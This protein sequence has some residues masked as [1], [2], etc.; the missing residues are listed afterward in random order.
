MKFL[1]LAVK[2]FQLS[3]IRVGIGWM[4]GLL[5]FN[6][7]RVTITDLGAIGLVVLTLIGLH[8]FLSPLQVFW[9]RL[10]DR[11]PLFGYRRSPSILLG[12]LVTSLVFLALPGLAVGLGQQALWATL[13][14]LLLFGVFGLAMAAIGTATFALIAEVTTQSERGLVVAVTHT[15]TI[16]SGIISA[17]VAAAI[18]PDYDPQKMWFL[19]GLTPFITVGL[20]LLGLLGMERRISPTEHA[21]LLAQA[22]TH[23]HQPDALRAG[24]HLFSHNRQ[25]RLFF[26]FM[27][28]AILGI[29]LQDGILENYGGTVFGM[30]IAETNRFTQTWGSGVL[31]GMLLVGL[32]TLR[33]ALSKKLLA[34]A[35][36]LGTA[37]GLALVALSAFTLQQWLIHPALLVMGF[38]VGIFNVGAISMMME[39]S[40]EGQTGLY[41][42]IWGMAQGLGN[43][44]ANVGSGVL[45]TALIESNVLS[46]AAGYGAI[47]SLEALLMMA[48][49]AVLLRISVQKFQ[50]CGQRELTTVMALDPAV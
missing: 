43:G 42:G 46:T 8:H 23:A 14:G 1:P 13:L 12:S 3:L 24:L 28:L 15:I 35:G 36:G 11:Y 39:M 7:N 32:L 9:G 50:S 47:F 2:T 26:L 21:A 41:M 25:V 22:D 44:L 19:Y 16:L 40:I 20:A 27:L 18:M 30:N 17:G 5:Y 33:L 48:A 4:F 31:L 34:T 38:C 45:H 29:F 6:F 37:A 10:A 49:V